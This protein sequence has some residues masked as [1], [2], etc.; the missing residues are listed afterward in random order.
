VLQRVL[1]L[2]ALP[3]EGE[4]ESE[5][6]AALATYLWLLSQH[7]RDFAQTVAESLRDRRQFFWARKLAGELRLPDGSAKGN[8][9]E[10]SEERTGEAPES[11]EALHRNP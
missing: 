7:R 6:D 5:G 10:A 3:A 11:A 8:G 2:S 4:F 1:A 9:R